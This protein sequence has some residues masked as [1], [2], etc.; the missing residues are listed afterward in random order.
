MKFQ[1]LDNDIRSAKSS[2]ESTLDSVFKSELPVTK[3][4]SKFTNS[5]SVEG[6]FSCPAEDGVDK[7]EYFIDAVEGKAHFI[8][9]SEK[10]GRVEFDL[11]VEK[12]DY[13]K[14]VKKIAAEYS[15][16]GYKEIK[17]SRRIQSSKKSSEDILPVAVSAVTKAFELLHMLKF[18]HW[19][20]AGINFNSDHEKMDEHY[21]RINEDLDTLGEI[22]QRLNSSSTV[23][24][25]EVFEF[26]RVDITGFEK[27]GLWKTLAE[28]IKLFLESIELLYN[29]L[30]PTYHDIAS[31]LDA[32]QYYWN[33]LLT[34]KIKQIDLDS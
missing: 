4:S 20:A 7:V 25:V 8:L 5:W 19:S 22:T 34:Y 6:K 27:Q 28:Q 14:M 9:D 16:L 29:I 2:V 23:I 21:G 12:D 24:P 10:F 3:V 18:L 33:K 15:K 26:N 32:I 17:S 31:E 13:T 11:K 1:I 30:P